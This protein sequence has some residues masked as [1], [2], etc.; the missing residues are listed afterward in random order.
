M[1]PRQKRL[2]IVVGGLAAIGIAAALILNAFQSN[3]VF[4]FMPPT[5]VA[6]GE[7]PKGP[8][9]PHRRAGEGGQP[10]ARRHH[11]PL[12]RHRHGQE[13]PVSYRGI[14]PD[15]FSEG[16]AWSPGQH[17]AGRPVHRHRGAR[18]A[19]RELHAARGPGRRRQGPRG[20]KDLEAV[21]ERGEAGGLVSASCAPDWLLP[22]LLPEPLTPILLT[23]TPMI[24]EIGTFAL[25]LALLV[26]LVQGT[27][28]LIGAQRAGGG[29]GGARADRPRPRCSCSSRSPSAA[30]PRPSSATTS[31]CST[32]PSIPTRG[33]RSNTA[34]PA[35]GAATR[36]RC[37]CGC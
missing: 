15:L 13:I 19:R 7:A 31:R 18:Q 2:A 20:F 28:P 34:S 26:A 25:V 5:Q 22:V 3:L 30:S 21:R 36:A 23:R 35:C 12:R 37:C 10:A 27:L 4:F 1:K 14:L 11:R 8:R 17:R 9:L 16:K 29:L 6:S 32:W 33:C 24:P